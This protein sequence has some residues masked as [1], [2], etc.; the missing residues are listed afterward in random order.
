MRFPIR[1]LVFAA[2]ATAVAPVAATAVT[3]D[4]YPADL[5][6]TISFGTVR[7]PSTYVPV[8]TILAERTTRPWSS[9]TFVCRSQGDKPTPV[10]SLE[11][12]SQAASLNAPNGVVYKTNVPGLG[13]RVTYHALDFMGHATND[14][15]GPEPRNIWFPLPFPKPVTNPTPGPTPPPPPP[16]PKSHTVAVRDGHFRVQ[17]IKT[18]DIRADGKLPDGPLASMTFHTDDAGAPIGPVQG[19]VS[20]I[21]STIIVPK[22]DQP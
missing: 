11:Y 1:T 16:P 5:P 17:L 22:A 8:G 7:L 4:D 9:A 6:Q 14:D 19:I 15:G 3:C 10:L 20:M 12:L 13:I 18:G 21:D 2:I